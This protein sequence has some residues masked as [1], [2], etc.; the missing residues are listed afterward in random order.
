MDG[1]VDGQLDGWR[2]RRRERKGGG[3]DE[4]SGTQNGKPSRE[5]CDGAHH[6]YSCRNS[7]SFGEAEA[8]LC[9]GKG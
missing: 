4:P 6:F 7:Q 3:T 9:I 2:E 8:V 1:W 5:R